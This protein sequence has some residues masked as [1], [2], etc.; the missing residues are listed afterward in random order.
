MVLICIWVLTR[1]TLNIRIS[2][3]QLKILPVSVHYS[4]PHVLLIMIGTPHFPTQKSVLAQVAITM[5]HRL[6]G[7]KFMFHSS[8]VW[9][10]KHGWVLMRDLFLAG[11]GQPPHCDLY[12]QWEERVSKV[13]G[14]SFYRSTNPMLHVP[15]MWPYLNLINH[16]PK[17]SSPN[18][19]KLGLQYMNLGET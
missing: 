13:S 6:S 8:A 18:P 7:L 16:L 17:A 19:T 14:I 4:I 5:C 1:T 15:P 11:R 2:N 3:M 12:I 10:S 9:K